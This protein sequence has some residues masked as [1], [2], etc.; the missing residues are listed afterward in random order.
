MV[1]ENF[2]PKNHFDEK[3]ESSFEEREILPKYS[4]TEVLP[5]FK[6]RGVNAQSALSLYKKQDSFDSQD[7]SP[8]P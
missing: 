3:S 8:N 7:Q 4:E 6:K 5:R 2:S 1:S